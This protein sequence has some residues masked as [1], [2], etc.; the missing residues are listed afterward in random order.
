MGF[1]NN[2]KQKREEKKCALA[3][4]VEECLDKARRGRMSR[5]AR[6]SSDDYS[7]ALEENDQARFNHAIIEDID[8]EIART[9]QPL[10]NFIDDPHIHS[11]GFISP[12]QGVHSFV[13]DLVEHNTYDTYVQR[14]EKKKTNKHSSATR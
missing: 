2:L 9:C 8:A 7:K 5:V 11:Q 14:D 6:R 3:E 1:W 10:D 12:K 13:E 4:N